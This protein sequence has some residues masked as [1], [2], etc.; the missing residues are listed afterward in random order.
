MS[1][2]GKQKRGKVPLQEFLSDFRSNMT[3][4]ELKEK[5][6]L[7]ARGFVSL[8]KALLDRKVISPQDLTTRKQMAIQRDLALQS[9]FLAGLH[10]CPNCGHPSPQRFEVCPACGFEVAAPVAEQADASV[11][12]GGDSLYVED[13]PE[14]D[15][16]EDQELVLDY[17]D[18]DEE[19]ISTQD[20]DVIPP[21]DDDVIPPPEGPPDETDEKRSGL[22]SLRSFFSKKIKK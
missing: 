10:L 15:D 7:S 5:Y 17:G 14:A 18:S 8:V 1:P 21:E 20:D 2:N 22:K 12:P 6:S 3:D 19:T 11:T 9:Q 4:H 16:D 13:Q